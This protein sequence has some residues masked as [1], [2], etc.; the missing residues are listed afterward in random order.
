MFYEIFDLKQK[1]LQSGNRAAI[2][3]LAIGD[4]YTSAWN[5]LFKTSWLNYAE[6]FNFDLY[7]I[8]I[9]LDN[10]EAAKSIVLTWQKCLILEQDW[11]QS[12]ER[13][14]WIDVDIAISASAPNILDYV[15]END[16][17]GISSENLQLAE[18]ELDILFEQEHN[19]NMLPQH[20]DA[21]WKNFYIENLSG[22]GFNAEMIEVV[23]NE[24]FNSGVMV[25]S[26]KYHRNILKLVYDTRKSQWSQ[27]QPL[28]TYYLKKENSF[29]RLSPRFNWCLYPVINLHFRYCDQSHKMASDII[30][31]F[32]KTEF[33]KSYF[34]HFNGSRGLINYLLNAIPNAEKIFNP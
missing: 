10:S 19:I 7:V 26:P 33:K 1:V 13:I 25:L 29:I 16:K 20:R 15:T 21:I 11:A 30:P 8:Y 27:E 4:F 2:V 17:V 24:I 23:N 18:V 6:K 14:I 3:T 5:K 32:V 12:Y 22:I 9:P 31:E 28:M 34:L